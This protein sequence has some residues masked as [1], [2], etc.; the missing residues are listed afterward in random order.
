MT[1]GEITGRVQAWLGLQSIDDFDELPLIH[2]MIYR[3]TID[4]LS[5]TRCVVRCIHL[6][7]TADV[8]EYLLSQT[9]LSL[10]DVDDGATRRARRDDKT[11]GTFTLIRSDV[12]HLNPAP[13]EDGVLDVWAVPLPQK[14]AADTDQLGAEAFGAIPE[15]FQ[16]AVELYTLWR[17]SDYS[18]NAGSRK[19]ELYRAQY[20]GPDGRGG[21]LAQIRTLVN[22]RG[23]AR[24]PD[25]RVTLATSMGRRDWF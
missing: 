2:D 5:R 24:A 9:I 8:T 25:R 3:G 20:E 6:N 12:L 7:T 10:V 16:D 18:D 23:T 14:M 19:G 4:V 15:D 11:N 21:R 1:R 17:A 22:K 13:S